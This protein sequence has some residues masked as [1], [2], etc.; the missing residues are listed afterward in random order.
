MKVDR[1]FVDFVE[2]QSG[3]FGQ[4]RFGVTHCGCAIAVARTK[5]ALSVDERVALRKVLRHANECFIGSAVAMGV[6]A[7]EY[8]A[9]DTGAFDGFGAGVA[10]KA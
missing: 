3:D 2:Q 4:A 8:V 5:V 10:A 7:A 6:V 9:H 1:A